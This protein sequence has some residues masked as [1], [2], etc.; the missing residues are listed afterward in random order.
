MK[1]YKVYGNEPTQLTLTEKASAVYECT[2]PIEIRENEDGTYNITGNLDRY[3]N[4]AESVNRYLEDVYDDMMRFIHQGALDEVPDEVEAEYIGGNN[5][6]YYGKLQ[7]GLFFK[8]TDCNCYEVRILDT[9]LVRSII[10]KR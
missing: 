10:G 8:A 4:S 5:Y 3:C 9:D 1:N 7:D 2:D 6:A